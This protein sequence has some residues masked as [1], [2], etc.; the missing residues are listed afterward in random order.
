MKHPFTPSDIDTTKCASC[1]LDEISHGDSAVCESCDAIGPCEIISKILM[2]EKCQAREIEIQAELKQTINPALQSNIDSTIRIRTDFFNSR[3]VSIEHLRLHIETDESIPHDKKRFKLAEQLKDRITHLSQTLIDKKSELEM[4]ASEH[5][6]I[7]VYLNNLASQITAEERE[8]LRLSDI[9]YKST[10]PPTK[11]K[12]PSNKAGKIDRVLIRKYAVEMNVSELT[13][14]QFVIRNNND[15]EK[16]IA[17]FK[18]MIASM[19]TE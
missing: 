8:R 3:T 15:V 19:K 18:T 4:L 9:N 5:R 13:L 10:P 12:S 6:A 11:V 2:C 16:G 1:K 7:Q 17:A 14:T